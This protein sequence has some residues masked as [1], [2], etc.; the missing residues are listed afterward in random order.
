MTENNRKI[1]LNEYLYE[2]NN[3][4]RYFLI[5]DFLKDAL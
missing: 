1:L 5:S 2:K 3:H 4:P